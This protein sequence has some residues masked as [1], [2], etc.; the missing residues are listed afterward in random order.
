[1]TG[2]VMVLPPAY[3][4]LFAFSGLLVSKSHLTVPDRENGVVGNRDPVD[5]TGQ[6]L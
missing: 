5:I 6:I 4:L 3:P 2:R 1:M